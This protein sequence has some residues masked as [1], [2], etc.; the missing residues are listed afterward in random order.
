LGKPTTVKEMMAYIFQSG[1]NQHLYHK[2]H[3]LAPIVGDINV[4]IELPQGV[5]AEAEA[6]HALVAGLH[7]Y[8]IK[9]ALNQ[10]LPRER[11]ETDEVLLEIEYQTNAYTD[12]V[13]AQNVSYFSSPLP[14]IE[15]RIFIQG[16]NQLLRRPSVSIV[17]EAN[18]RFATVFDKSKDG[19]W[20][21]SYGNNQAEIVLD[22]PTV[23]TVY[24]IEFPTMNV[25]LATPTESP[26]P[27]E[28]QLHSEGD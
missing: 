4:K 2:I 13:D 10:P 25:A 23:A 8:W 26:L 27:L 22:Y 9:F 20:E 5:Y 12:D 24:R 7:V 18:G 6:H 3:L 1:K 17:E 16:G 28:R 21:T 19:T 11:V 14:T 15:A